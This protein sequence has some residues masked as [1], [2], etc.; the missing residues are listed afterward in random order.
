M[1]EIISARQVTVVF[2]EFRFA[3]AGL[4]ACAVVSV[5]AHVQPDDPT[6]TRAIA[7]IIQEHC[8]PCHRPGDVAPFSLG[9]S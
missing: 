1:G 9:P 2:Q 5:A 6:D 4:G 8:V 3:F 7:P